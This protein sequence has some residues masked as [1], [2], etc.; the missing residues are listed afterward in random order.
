MVHIYTHNGVDYPSVTTIIQYARAE[1]E[2]LTRWKEK[3]PNWEK[4]TRNSQIIGTLVHYRILNPLSASRLELPEINIEEVPSDAYTKIEIAEHMFEELNLDIGYPRMVEKFV[5][6]EK[7]RYAGK[8]D[9][10]AP[11]DGVYTLADLKTSATVQE[12]H[13]LQMGG[14][15]GA[16][17]E[18]PERAYLIS[19][20][21]DTKKNPAL[22]AHIVEMSRDELE[23]KYLEFVE[24][25]EE[26]HRQGLCSKLK[27]EHG[28]CK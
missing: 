18:K 11:I 1:P 15:Y 17:P 9:L 21:P 3:T 14:Y 20:H 13:K 26:F 28:T 10:V 23:G 19:V 2:Q 16:L 4:Q 5:L 7:H 12:T 22:R 27:K 8:V 25:V 24:L 6:S